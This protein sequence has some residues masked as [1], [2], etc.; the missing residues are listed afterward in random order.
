MTA[1]ILC[2][3]DRLE[4][5]EFQDLPDSVTNN[6]QT[7]INRLCQEYPT[8]IDCQAIVKAPISSPEGCYHL[9]IWLTLSESAIG[10]TGMKY[11]RQLRVD[12][13]PNPDNYQEDIDVAI[14]S[15]FKLARTKLQEYSLS[16]ATHQIAESS[17]P[18]RSISPVRPLRRSI[19]YAGG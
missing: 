6:I 1:S 2:K 3:L 18:D 7:Q 17:R 8:L 10:K 5:I 4:L 19:G 16:A 11:H 13:T 14:W 9:Q 12:R 15:A